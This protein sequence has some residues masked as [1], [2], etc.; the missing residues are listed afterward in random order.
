MI[1]IPLT[2]GVDGVVQEE[3]CNPEQV[4]TKYSADVDVSDAGVQ[5]KVKVSE[6]VTTA[7]ATK[8]SSEKPEQ[9]KSD[10]TMP[11]KKAKTLHPVDSNASK[12]EEKEDS[13]TMVD[14]LAKQEMLE[15]EAEEVLPE[16]S[17]RCSFRYGYVR[18]P[19]YGCLTCLRASGASLKGWEGD[20]DQ[21]VGNKELI[22][23]LTQEG[24]F[25]SLS[26]VCYSCSILCHGSHDLLELFQKRA[27]R[28]DCGTAKDSA[29]HQCTLDVNGSN[30]K[31]DKEVDLV[32]KSNILNKENVY[33]QN[34]I[35]LYCFCNQ[36]Y[37][38][39]SAEM[40]LQCVLCEDWFHEQCIKKKDNL[41]KLPALGDWDDL[42]CG[43]CVGKHP[44][45]IRYRDSKQMPI[46]RNEGDEANLKC[47]LQ[48]PISSGEQPTPAPVIVPGSE[49][50]L[51]L[52]SKSWKKAL[53]RC[54]SCIEM[55]KKHNVSFLI[56][57]Y[58]SIED[59]EADDE[60]TTTAVDVARVDDRAKTPQ[61]AAQGASGNKAKKTSMYEL[62]MEALGK[63]ELTDSDIRDAAHHMSSLSESLKEY[64]KQFVIENK[65]V[66]KKDIER[67]FQERKGYA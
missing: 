19:I 40:M 1:P 44:F 31:G 54:T 24:A 5:S 22:D 26:G 55:Y 9:Y 2:E 53:C 45:I 27:F 32:D 20:Y 63:S 36:K 60:E 12:T 4:S 56:D 38:E 23:K 10:D 65:T 57:G 28:C 11:R 58:P 41:L 25:D 39:N 6:K 33:N 42:V 8:H 29:G 64:L 66:T 52:H 18:Q 61:V 13:I 43:E 49:P 30:A 17:N 67:F 16:P 37:D 35:G 15:K 47:F 59:F 7:A 21:L 48:T 46:E 51:F 34:F 3:K 50:C 14:F 62:G